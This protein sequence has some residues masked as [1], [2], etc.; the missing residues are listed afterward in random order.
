[1]TT[2]NNT[3]TATALEAAR[4]AAHDADATEAGGKAAIRLAREARRL[5]ATEAVEAT[6][7]TA[8]MLGSVG[9]MLVAG[10]GRSLPRAVPEPRKDESPAD[11]AGRMQRYRT[12]RAAGIVSALGA[13]QVEDALKGK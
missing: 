13:K 5:A 6:G 10:I 9:A 1:M 11:F 12:R 3:T 8:P 4:R 7:I 2:E